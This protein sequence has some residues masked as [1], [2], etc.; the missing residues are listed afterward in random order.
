MSERVGIEVS[1]A[2]AEAAGLADVDVVAAYP[3]TPQTH[4]V[5]HLSEMVA[6][7]KLD[8]EF[9][10]VESEHSALS[11][12]IGSAGAGARTFTSTSS[13]GLALMNEVVYI[14]SSL[15]MPIVMVVSNRSLSGPLSIWNDHSD[16]MSVRDTG[17]IQVFAENG[18]E[19]FD[20]VFWAFRVG[21]DRGVLLPVM[22]HID[23]FILSHMVEP[24]EWVEGELIKAYLKPYE[25]LHRLHPDK[26]V[27]MGA[28]A[29]PELYTEAKKAQNEALKGSMEV[30]LRGWQEWGKLTGR[31]YRPVET[32]RTEGAEVVLMTMGSMGETACEAVDRM[33]EKGKSV[34][35]LKLRLWRPF[36]FEAFRKAVGGAKV[37]VVFD[38]ALSYGGPG[39]PVS[40]EVRA[41]LYGEQQRPR[42]V[43]FVGGLA[44]RDVSPDDFERMVE[45]A[46]SSSDDRQEN[47]RM[48]GVRE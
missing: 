6:E 44:G 23:G 21:E 1:I 9:V 22:V 43:N 10:P 34:G 40:S 31:H 11:V 33:R 28:F 2:V 13:Q 26:A 14:A 19:A 41:A 27:T 5:E 15:R 46:L 37:L 8:A 7:G 48:Y 20:E 39:G 24:I 42:V 47:Y 38:R 32:Y 45:E 29:M 4:I 18:Q 30:I 35:V 16:V 36:P 17:W 25:P 12:C 3:I